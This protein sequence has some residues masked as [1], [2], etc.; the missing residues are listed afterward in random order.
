MQAKGKTQGTVLVLDG[1]HLDQDDLA[2]L[3]AS[4]RVQPQALRVVSREAGDAERKH[5][6]DVWCERQQ[7]A[8]QLLQI[9]AGIDRYSK[10]VDDAFVFDH[11]QKLCTAAAR[12]MALTKPPETKRKPSRRKAS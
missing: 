9:D 6:A 4:G 11:A 2:E 10:R 12:L 1:T 5:H 7:I 8:G 3:V